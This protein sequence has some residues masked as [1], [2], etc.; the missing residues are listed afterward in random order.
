MTL[1]N[2]MTYLLEM[3]RNSYLG[4]ADAPL[5]AVIHPQSLQPT[6]R[7]PSEQNFH[8]HVKTNN[9]DQRRADR[10]I[11]HIHLHIPPEIIIPRAP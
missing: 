4:S 10:L 6:R 8:H 11:G 5:D 3:P 1:A 9:N 7:Q 2:P